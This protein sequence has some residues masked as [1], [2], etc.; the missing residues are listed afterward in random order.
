MNAGRFFKYNGYGRRN[1]INFK[2][3]YLCIKMCIQQIYEFLLYIILL[4]YRLYIYFQSELFYFIKWVEKYPCL[5][6]NIGIAKKVS[7]NKTHNFRQLYL[8]VGNYFQVMYYHPEM[9]L[10]IRNL[11]TSACFI[12]GILHIKAW[13]Q[14]FW[15]FSLFLAHKNN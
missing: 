1:F 11:S 3:C 8:I 6:K 12:I 13:F 4:N 14:Y 9:K 7:F 5:R 2:K 15:S 10:L